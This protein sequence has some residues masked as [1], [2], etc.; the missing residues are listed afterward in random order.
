MVIEEVGLL[1]RY[2]KVGL[3]I[4]S[5]TVSLYVSAACFLFGSQKNKVR[6][7][8][9]H[10]HILRPLLECHLAPIT[11]QPRNILLIR[12]IS[13]LQ[14]ASASGS[15]QALLHMSGSAPYVRLY[16][17]LQCKL[18]QALVSLRPAPVRPAS[19]LQQASASG[20]QTLLQKASTSGSTLGSSE[21][22]LR[23]ALVSLRPAPVRPASG[24]QQASASG[25][26]Q[27]L[28][29]KASMSG[30]TH[31]SSASYAWLW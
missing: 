13:R 2:S 10:A 7:S 1:D 11:K 4:P 5:H 29:Q 14:Q 21:C 12:F 18:R 8:G 17:R 19:V 25:S 28:L 9:L 31:G 30:S 24:L 23:Q 22:K 20:S 6:S 3:W 26:R 15:R 16:A 27:A